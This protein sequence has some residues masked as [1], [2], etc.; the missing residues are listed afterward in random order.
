MSTFR[1]LLTDFSGPSALDLLTEFRAK[2][3]AL[4]E[5]RRDE[6]REQASRFLEDAP[7]PDL[8]AI[9]AEVDSIRYFE[10][11]LN[12]LVT[13]FANEATKPWRDAWADSL[14]RNMATSPFALPSFDETILGKPTGQCEKCGGA[15]FGSALHHCP[16]RQVADNDD[17]VIRCH[18]CKGTSIYKRTPEGFEIFHG[19]ESLAQGIRL[20]TKPIEIAP[21]T[22]AGGRE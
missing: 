18:R 16:I 8:R 9:Y 13:A 6:L 12:R 1:G 3:A 4:V 7:T 11:E 14:S 21:M 19:C 15:L 20:E 22:G 17:P 5:R 10:Q 2:Y